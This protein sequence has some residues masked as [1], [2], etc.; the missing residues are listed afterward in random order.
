MK[1]NVLD[2]VELTADQRRIFV[3]ISQLYE[4]YED[5]FRKNESFAGSMRWKK[6][7]G[8]EY[9]FK[10]LDRRGNGKGLGLRSEETEAIL[11]DFKKGKAKAK[12]RLASVKKRLDEQSKFC[13]AAR[14]QRVPTVVAKIL[15]ILE[16]FKVLGNRLIIVGTNALYAYEALAGV[17]FD[18]PIMAT[19]DLDI[20]FDA[21]SGVTLAGEEGEAIGLLDILKKADRSFSLMGEGAFRAV[22][23]DGYMV[24]LIRP[25]PSPPWKD[26]PRSV[27]GAD[28]MQA[29]DTRKLDWMV[30]SPK[31]SQIVVGEDGFPARIVV[32]DP[33]SFV[34][35]KLWLSQQ[36]DRQ[37]VKKPRDRMQAMA[38]M[39]LI[40][41]YL[42]QYKL[43][44]SDLK[45]FPKDVVEL[46]EG[47]V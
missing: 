22:N 29:V 15:R 43:T 37:P 5:A 36:K 11:G 30:S 41:Q 42:P 9:L 13:K 31:L 35:H 39:K 19:E 21:R 7:K 4:A 26:Q 17:F 3:D 25:M 27:G 33:R 14:I 20:V 40:R 24:D 6:S 18:R 8:R 12:E 47:T 28:D 38:V 44:P 32:P 45:M 34:V 10:Q 1:E 2:P 16:K 46:P 23:R